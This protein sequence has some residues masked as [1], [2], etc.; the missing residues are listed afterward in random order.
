MTDDVG[1]EPQ[2]YE[3]LGLAIRE[4]RLAQG[5]TLTALATQAE[6]SQPFLSQIENGRARPSMMSLYRI[7]HALGTT[8]QALFGGLLD[9][10]SGPSVV[11]AD[12]EGRSVV[13]DGEAAES[14]C[15]LLLAGES[16]FHVL[17]FVGLPHEFLE[18]WEHEGFE[19]VYV[20]KGDIEIDVAGTV[21]VM[22][23]GDFL[24]Y[25]ARLPHRF[26]AIKSKPVRVLMMEMKIGSMPGQKATTHASRK[27]KRA[28]TQRTRKATPTAAPARSTV[29]GPARPTKKST[30]RTR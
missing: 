15:R 25:P 29:K 27:T 3:T 22:K 2:A 9:S 7:A 12:Q 21:T 30:L 4:R 19:A 17:E 26:R 14:M 18:Y 28:R 10:K 6:L 1:L 20:V 11:R 5:L 13:V 24:S 16:P 8:P 23:T